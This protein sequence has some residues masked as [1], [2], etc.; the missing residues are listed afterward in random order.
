MDFSSLIK[1]QNAELISHAPQVSSFNYLYLYA[2][3]KIYFNKHIIFIL[4]DDISSSK[5]QHQQS[6]GDILDTIIPPR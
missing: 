5:S 4:Q 2:L 3:N 1:Y 6:D